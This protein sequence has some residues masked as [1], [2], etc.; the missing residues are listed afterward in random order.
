MPDYLMDEFNGGCTTA[1][2]RW[3]QPLLAAVLQEANARPLQAD[4]RPRLNH[5]NQFAS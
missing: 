5:L 1:D 2:G 4:V 3:E